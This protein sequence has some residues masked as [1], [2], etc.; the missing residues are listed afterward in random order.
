ML[1]ASF[2]QRVGV[3]MTM[4]EDQLFCISSLLLV[5]I[6]TV[7]GIVSG[8]CVHRLGYICESGYNGPST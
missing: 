2:V 6:H 8:R 5:Q 4:G 3:E 7:V 1:I